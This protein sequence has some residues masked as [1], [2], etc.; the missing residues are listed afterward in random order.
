MP[1]GFTVP[2]GEHWAINGLVTVGHASV[3]VFG[4]LS[5]WNATG[6]ARMA[7]HLHFEGINNAT[8]VGGPFAPITDP[9][10][11]VEGS[12]IPDLVGT[13]KLAWGF[14]VSTHPTWNATDEMVQAPLVPSEISRTLGFRKHNLGDAVRLMPKPGSFTGEMVGLPVMNLTRD[15][16]ISGTAAGR[17]HFRHMSNQKPILE[18]VEFEYIGLNV[19]GRYPMHFHENGGALFGAV[20]SGCVVKR[21]QSHAFVPHSSHGMEFRDCISYDTL[22]EPYWWDK[23]DITDDTLFVG[24]IAAWAHDHPDT[25]RQAGFFLF[26]GDRNKILRCGAIGI[27]SRGGPNSVSGGFL[28]P[29]L[30]PFRQGDSFWFF[31]DN[32]AL[33]C[34]HSGVAVWQ[35]TADRHTIAT[36]GT[37]TAINCGEAGIEHGAYLNEY[38]Y[39]NFIIHALP[40]DLGIKSYVAPKASDDQPSLPDPDGYT[41]SWRHGLIVGGL[42][43][44]EMVPHP[45]E[46]DRVTLWLDITAIGQN[47]VKIAVDENKSLAHPERGLYDIVDWHKEGGAF[48]APADIVIISARPTMRLRLQADTQAWQIDAAGTVTPRAPF[49]SPSQTEVTP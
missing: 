27:T 40:G 21:S 2:A 8:F 31:E 36:V 43:A 29:E 25:L 7:T 23:G 17:S 30:A 16:K 20:V 33:A 41:N 32:F 24:C 6:T 34:S 48:L 4:R 45:R 10:L 39:Q 11:W 14:G 5:N 26:S 44:L 42:H 13:P 47:G 35:N 12:G 46:S 19:L 37:F 9:G 49:Y 1:D 22:Q 3:V 15:V 38:R 28:W 18:N